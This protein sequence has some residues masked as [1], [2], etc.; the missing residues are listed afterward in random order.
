M[1]VETLLERS[2]PSARSLLPVVPKLYVSPWFAVPSP[3][4]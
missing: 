4:V 3:A 2:V 1:T